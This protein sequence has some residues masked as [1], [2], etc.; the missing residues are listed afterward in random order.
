MTRSER[1]G[2]VRDIWRLRETTDTSKAPARRSSEAMSPMCLYV[3][4]CFD[5]EKE[6]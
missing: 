5:L 4:V 2:E 1:S 6:V 3:F